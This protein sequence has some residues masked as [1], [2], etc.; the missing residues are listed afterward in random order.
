MRCQLGTLTPD[1]VAATRKY[2][3]AG[4]HDQ[5]INGFFSALLARAVDNACT[6]FTL[7]EYQATLDA[8]L[9]NPRIGGNPK[10]RGAAHY[11]KGLAYE[12]EGMV[13]SA[14]EQL[15]RS[16]EAWPELDVRLQQLVWVLSRGR[17]DDAERYLELARQHLDRRIWSRRLREADLQAFEQQID[18]TRLLLQD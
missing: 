12:R 3:E 1:Q 13:D 7:A 4:S 9:R 17:V 8:A 15:D 16:Y 2:L 14:V 5:Q 18:Q 6:A 10:T 11:F